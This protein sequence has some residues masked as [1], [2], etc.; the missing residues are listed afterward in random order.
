MCLIVDICNS[1]QDNVGEI[2][3]LYSSSN[4][5]VGCHPVLSWQKTLFRICCFFF[6][7]LFI[8]SF[9]T[10]FIYL[11]LK[12]KAGKRVQASHDWFWFDF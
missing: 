2:S 6:I 10:F 8:Y 1:F 3:V 12:L 4:D 11:F 5:S 9:I 7:Y